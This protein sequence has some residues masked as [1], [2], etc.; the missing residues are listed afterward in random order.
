VFKRVVGPFVIAGVLAALFIA[1]SSSTVVGRLA[2]TVPVPR[3]DPLAVTSQPA[4]WQALAPVA[5][6]LDT[7]VSR[8]GGGE[9]RLPSDGNLLWFYSDTTGLTVPSASPY[10]VNNTVAISSPASPLAL[11]E[12]L[13]AQGMPFQLVQPGPGF[14]CPV[15]GALRYVWI[16]GAV[17]LPQAGW[18]KVLL[19]TTSYCVN[20]VDHSSTPHSVGL[21]EFDYSPAVGADLVHPWSGHV[22]IL[23]EDLWGTP[24]G[25]AHPALGSDGLV[26]VYDCPT[27]IVGSFVMPV[28]CRTGRVSP[29]QAAD[30]SKYRYWNGASWGATTIAGA[31]YM[32]L[33]DTVSPVRYPAGMFDVRY[34][35]ALGLYVLAGQAWPGY[36]GTS[37]IRVAQTPQGPWSTPVGANYVGCSGLNGHTCYGSEIATDLSDA[38]HLGLVYYDQ[39]GQDPYVTTTGAPIA[40]TVADPP[41]TGQT[42]FISLG[43]TPPANRA[44]AMTIG[45]VTT[46][47]GNTGTHLAVATVKLSAA[48]TQTVT[49][50]WATSDGTATAGLDYTA[51]AG[52][53][54]FLAGRTTAAV[55]VT[56]IGNTLSQTNRTF[57]MTLSAPTN[58]VITDDQGIGTIVDDDPLSSLAITDTSVAQSTGSTVTAQL[59]VSL[60]PASGQV[61][62]VPYS[63][64]DGTAVAPKDYQAAS[65]VLTFA[66]GQ[67][68][69]TVPVTVQDDRFAEPT[70][71]FGVA[72]GTATGAT[73]SRASGTIT[74]TNT[75]P[76][77]PTVNISDVTVG[78]GGGN[79]VLTL[80]RSGLMTYAS[81]VSWTT[82]DGT[83][84]S[85]T[86][87]VG[88]SGTVTFAPGQAVATVTVAVVQGTINEADESFSVLLSN[89][90]AV[91]LSNTSGTA[92]IVSNVA[93]PVVSISGGGTLV[94]G[95]GM[96]Y[97]AKVATF[98]VSLSA[99]SGR[100]V[101]VGLNTTPVTS[102]ASDF[103]ATSTT[104]TFDPG[105]TSKTI[106]IA[107]AQDVV[108]ED[109]EQFTADLS[110]PTFVTIGTGSALAT[111]VDKVPDPTVSISGKTVNESDGTITVALSL[112]APSGKTVTATWATSDFTARAPTN[113]LAASGT[114]T[115][116][117]G[118]TTATVP[119]TVIDDNSRQANRTFTVALTG[120][121]NAALWLRT[122]AITVI[123]SDPP[124]TASI[125]DV[126]M[127]EGSGFYPTTNAVFTVTL[128]APTGYTVT[129]PWATADGTAQAPADYLSASGTITFSPNQT[130]AI[131]NV[132]VVGDTFYEPDQTASVNLGVPT[133]A[134]VGKGAGTLNIVN[135]DPVPT[136]SVT[137]TTVNEGAGTF[138]VPVTLNGPTTDTVTV[139]WSTADQTAISPT[140]YL[141]ASGTVTFT[142]GQTA[143]T[144]TVSVVDDLNHGPTRSLYVNL[145]GPTRA[146]LG[147][148]QAI[149]NIIDNDPPAAVSVQNVTMIEGNGGL[150]PTTGALFQITLSAPTA[151]VVTV[152]WSTA[153][154]TAQAPGDY[155]ATS[156]TIT[157]W[158]GQTTA[159]IKVS[160]V[161]DKV[162]ELD[163]TAFVNLGIPTNAT[164]GQGTG[165]LTILND[166]PA[167]P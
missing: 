28:G 63:T 124:P 68:V 85:G 40:H 123:D 41:V 158:P 120:A 6:Q 25:M 38:N 62:T 24:T 29:D 16:S 102:D 76:P 112:S 111:I 99:P 58:A 84:T 148:G 109:A 52:T 32:D 156:G 9:V 4:A 132:A 69:M 91:V 150:F 128:S 106:T 157:F 95:A 82:V 130:A 167:P 145:S 70:R 5:P 67:T 61:I 78:E 53:V 79:A 117:P 147:Q 31:A 59:T 74:V 75:G 143:A 30:G 100:T 114:V 141:A 153:D 103:V 65:G 36:N 115:F 15:V 166:D 142:P 23:S 113:Y 64:V 149:V 96:L 43:V 66:P 2:A 165:T 121:A 161:G 21:A 133:N 160:V 42:H 118:Q 83:A 116:A 164:I 27:G 71:T 19:W 81:T 1:P 12:P 119:V 129:V 22:K 134:I 7:K 54:T 138:T 39:N 44:P 56:I 108:A 93:Y 72:L 87:Y 104:V 8:D 162:Y 137:G 80:T 92:T 47:E 125:S 126:A 131:I 48:S 151:Y 3:L 98:T 97:P 10:L 11:R 105:Q 60:T 46:A 101:T 26:Y 17:V 45:D 88:A 140:N 159:T 35:P 13:S 49:A 163:E 135:D 110:S 20:P 73:V 94:E 51:R 89:P 127:N 107:I 86:D 33:G 146:T 34:V 90:D 55:A 14:T 144:V 136:V 152:S 122:A 18:D 139:G 155:L 77:M 57:V 37:L 50:H 154:G